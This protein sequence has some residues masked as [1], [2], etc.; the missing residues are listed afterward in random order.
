M[1]AH[2][3]RNVIAIHGRPTTVPDSNRSV[4]DL[5]TIRIGFGTEVF[6]DQAEIDITSPTAE[7]EIFYDP[8]DDLK[9]GDFLT[10]PNS[11]GESFLHEVKNI[12]NFIP[13]KK[14][15]SAEADVVRKAVP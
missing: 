9:P 4:Q 10:F 12:R 15:G 2:A 3:R 8:C 7:F 5:G 11:E 1:S 13:G 6:T 14:L